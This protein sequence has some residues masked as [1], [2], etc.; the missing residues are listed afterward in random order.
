MGV[1]ASKGMNPAISTK[2]ITPQDHISDVEP[3]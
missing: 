1:G 3:T 2:R